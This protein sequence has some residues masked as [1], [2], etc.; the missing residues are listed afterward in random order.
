MRYIDR[1]KGWHQISVSSDPY[2]RTYDF[3][4]RKT[5]TS[6]ST[7]PKAWEQVLTGNS[8]R[9]DRNKGSL[10]RENTLKKEDWEPLRSETKGRTKERFQKKRDQAQCMRKPHTSHDRKMMKEAL[11]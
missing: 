4:A 7:F 2:F 10:E 11:Q 8:K 6:K 5:L 9:K 1:G 3:C